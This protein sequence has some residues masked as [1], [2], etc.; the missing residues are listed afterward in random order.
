M[1]TAPFT[2]ENVNYRQ[3]AKVSVDDEIVKTMKKDYNR[4]VIVMES[5]EIQAVGTVT[6]TEETKA[7]K[8]R[9][10]D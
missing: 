9:N 1:I 4:H 7:K 5:D 2:L 6:T 10:G 8:K 3:G